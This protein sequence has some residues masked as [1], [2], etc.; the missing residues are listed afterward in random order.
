MGQK[1]HPLIF[2]SKIFPEYKNYYNNFNKFTDVI[3]CINIYRY[4]VFYKKLNIVDVYLRKTHSEVYMCLLV[5]FSK[6][7]YYGNKKLIYTILSSIQK[8]FNDTLFINLYVL[9]HPLLSTKF[10]LNYIIIRYKSY[11]SSLRKLVKEIVILLLNKY[12]IKGIKLL[13]SGRINGVQRAKTE[14]FKFNEVSLHKLNLYVRYDT[15]DLNTKY[16]ILGFKLWLFF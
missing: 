14:T 5:L 3:T 12:K 4:I 10:I 9:K 1:V 11:K 15:I 16:G 8:N 2:R 6:N 13:V 7:Q